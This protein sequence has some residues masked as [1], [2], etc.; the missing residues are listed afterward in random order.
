MKRKEKKKKKGGRM[1]KKNQSNKRGK[2]HPT[3]H[4]AVETE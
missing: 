2:L 3:M 1:S 4:A